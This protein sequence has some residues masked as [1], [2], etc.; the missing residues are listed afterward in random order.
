MG[1]S[2]LSL[3]LELLEAVENI[4]HALLRQTIEDL[5]SMPLMLDNADIS[6]HR[7]MVGNC[8]HIEAHPLGEIGH[9]AGLRRQGIHDEQSVGVAQSL[10]NFGCHA[11]I[12][13]RFHP[14]DPRFC[15][16]GF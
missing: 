6:Q 7:K 15:R 12:R 3:G 8:G 11:E 10:E 14:S 9:A 16:H 13:R 5:G 4:K 1:K 2:F